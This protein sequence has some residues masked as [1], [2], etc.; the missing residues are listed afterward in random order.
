MQHYNCGDRWLLKSGV[1]LYNSLQFYVFNAFRKK[2]YFCQLTRITAYFNCLGFFEGFG[3]GIYFLFVLVEVV[4]TK[5]RTLQ[6]FDVGKI[7]NEKGCVQ[8]GEEWMEHNLLI[9]A[10]IAV[11]TAFLQVIFTSFSL[12]FPFYLSLPPHS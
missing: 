9:I 5:E 6:N 3:T 2:F 7:I 10:G 4:I 1:I 12:V 8:A 11:T